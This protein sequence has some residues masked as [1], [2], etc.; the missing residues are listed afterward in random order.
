MGDSAVGELLHGHLDKMARDLGLVRALGPDPEKTKGILLQMARKQGLSPKWIARLEAMYDINSGRASLPVDQRLALGMQ[1]LRN[2]LTSAQLG[3]TI[4]SSLPDFA[5]THA[6]ARWYDLD[7]TRMM[8]NYVKGIATGNAEE[9]RASAMRKGLILEVGLRGQNDAARDAI[10]DITAARGGANKWDAFLNG[11]ARTTGRMAEFVIRAQ[12]LAHHTQQLRNVIGGEL[13]EA[14]GQMASKPF[15]ELSGIENRLLREYGITDR[16]WD[17]LRTKGV[18]QGFMSPAKLARSGEG[19]ER[20]AASKLLGAIASIQRIAVPEGNSVTRAFVM[21][22]SAR[23]GT[24]SGEL[25]R[26]FMQYKGFGM[27][28]LMTTYFRAV[29]RLADGEGKWHRG[30]W[31]ASLVIGSTILGALSNQLK[32]IAAG[33][34]PE[35]IDTAKFWARAFAQGGAGGI[36]GNQLQGM[37]QAQRMDDAARLLTPMGGLALDLK[38][39][40]LGGLH[41]AE[42]PNQQGTT[43]ETYGIEAAKLARKYTPSLWYTRLAMDR[44]VHDTLTRMAD[45]DAASTFQRMRDNARKQGTAYWWAPGSEDLRRGEING[46]QRSPNYGNAVP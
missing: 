1:T 13:Q 42:N 19:A 43:R 8:G 41:G 14:L 21:A 31:I 39:M 5:F 44:L 35:P 45:P 38:Q 4:L 46:P 24:P 9:A 3:G 2:F 29:E 23:P 32:D 16:E 37:F 20:E 6:T 27:S 10:G 7:A 25:A 12:G 36:L 40:A 34:D 30:Q 11:A 22:G 28:A 15:A 18:D 26:S 33:K 17:L